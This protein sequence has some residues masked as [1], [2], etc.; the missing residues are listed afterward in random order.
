LGHLTW[1][2]TRERSYQWKGAVFVPAIRESLS[3]LEHVAREFLQSSEPRRKMELQN[4]ELL[5]SH[6]RGFLE[7][8]ELAL[9][10]RT[11]GSFPGRE[12]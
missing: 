8:E 1:R 3:F 4:V 12:T 10:K 7:K 11:P 2:R 6:M 9:A 5:A